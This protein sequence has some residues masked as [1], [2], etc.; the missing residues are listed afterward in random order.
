MTGRSSGNM[1]IF[2]HV[3]TL[4]VRDTGLHVLHCMQLNPEHPEGE[5]MKSSSLYS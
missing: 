2:V 3:I 1:L 5:K 4:I